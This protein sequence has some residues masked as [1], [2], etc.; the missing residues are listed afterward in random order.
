VSE[1]SIM[2][3]QARLLRRAKTSR[4]NPLISLGPA[5]LVNPLC[6]EQE[7]CRMREKVSQI[8]IIPFGQLLL[9]GG[10]ASE[11]AGALPA[12]TRLYSAPAGAPI[13]GSTVP[14]NSRCVR[15]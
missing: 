14:E 4:R 2:R 1:E 7:R 15:N 6:R 9:G 5:L 8:G 11:I 3:Q 12:R 13:L 10:H